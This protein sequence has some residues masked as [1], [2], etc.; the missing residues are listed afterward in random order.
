[1]KPPQARTN[2][3]LTCSCYSEKVLELWLIRHGETNWN[4]EGRIQGQTDRPL[5]N[6]GI[7]QAKRLAERLTSGHFDAVYASDSERA[8]HT[9]K[10]VVGERHICL[11]KRLRE[12][13]FGY[14]EG[15]TRAEFTSD[16]RRAYEAHRADPYNV[17]LPG[18]ESWTDVQT[19]VGAWLD[20]LPS[21]GRVVAFSH[22]GT[23]RAF[24]LS[25]MKPPHS[26]NWQLIFGNTSVT[27]LRLGE[28]ILIQTL[29]D[30]S[31]LEGLH[32]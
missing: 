25:I 9:A 24:I 30:V 7:E 17:A 4:V 10:I 21:E 8:H 22:G 14:L 12:I 32:G 23:I 29:N 19:R 15:K 11:D 28:R 18:G 27:R 16:E 6:L 5:N 1:M 13:N 20:T 2:I 26:L 3:A 31:H